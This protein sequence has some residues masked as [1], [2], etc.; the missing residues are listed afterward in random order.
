MK[1]EIN[2]V[3]DSTSIS[4]R[5]SP[6]DRHQFDLDVAAFLVLPDGGL[7]SW[8][9]K[10]LVSLLPE[11]QYADVRQ[12]GLPFHFQL[13]TAPSQGDLR[14]VV[15]DNLTGLIGSLNIPL[16]GIKTEAHH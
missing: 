14:L 10:N 1:T 7:I 13:D 3:V 6:S 9:H 16:A 5:E 2:L 8:V 4:F 12:H 15:R 11:M